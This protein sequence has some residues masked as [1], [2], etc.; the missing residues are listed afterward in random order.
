MSAI[1]FS[2]QFFGLSMHLFDFGVELFGALHQPIRC[3]AELCR[4]RAR[5][6]FGCHRPV[7][8]DGKL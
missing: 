6:V 7:F 8:L 5:V 3:F 2:V 4:T 1:G